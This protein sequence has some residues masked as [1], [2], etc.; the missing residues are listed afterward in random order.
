M[1]KIKKFV[2]AFSL[3]EL[4][5]SLIIMAAIAAAFTPVITKK[6]KA[7]DIIAGVGSL[8]TNCDNE[9]FVGPD[10]NNYCKLCNGD[11][12]LACTRS[13]ENNEYLDV[14]SCK[15]VSCTSAE[16]GYGPNCAKCD[17]SK[18]TKC[19]SGYY[20]NGNSCA[21]CSENCTE[22]NSNGCKK[23]EEGY[24]KISNGTC[25]QCGKGQKWTNDGCES[26]EPGTF[27]PEDAFIG[28]ECTP[29]TPNCAQCDS[30]TGICSNC[31]DGYNLNSNS[32]TCV[33]CPAGS[34]WN[35]GESQC[36]ANGGGDDPICPS[37]EVATIKCGDWFNIKGC[38]VCNGNAGCKQCVE[39]YH[40]VT[41][42]VNNHPT[43]SSIQSC[44]INEGCGE[45]NLP[46]C[47]TC[48]NDGTK[49]TKCE[50][51]YRPYNGVCV[52][53]SLTYYGTTAW[54]QYNAGAGQLEPDSSNP[55]TGDTAQ[56]GPTIPF[57]GTN[58]G[59]ESTLEGKVYKCTVGQACS[60][61]GGTNA[62]CWVTPTTMDF[63]T[64][65]C[66]NGDSGYLG[67]RRT[68]CNWYAANI[69]CAYNGMS[70]PSGSQF[71]SLTTNQSTPSSPSYLYNNTGTHF[72]S[73][74][75]SGAHYSKC[76]QTSNCYGSAND[77]SCKPSNIWS[78]SLTTSNAT[79]FPLVSSTSTGMS[80]TGAV[81]THAYSVRC[82]IGGGNCNLPHCTTCNNDGTKCTK[83]ESGYFPYN[84]VCVKTNTTTYVKGH[85]WTK[86]NAGAGQLEPDS[87]NPVTADTVQYGP[88]IPFKGLN[89]GT[90]SSYEEKI[91]KCTVGQAC[92]YGGTTPTCWVATSSADTSGIC[93]TTD[94]YS[95]CK[96]TLC[97]WYAANIIC[98]YNGMTL[99]ASTHT[100]N[101]WSSN[102]VDL[103]TGSIETDVSGNCYGDTERTFYPG[104]TG[105]KSLHLCSSAYSTTSFS[106]CGTSS[107]SCMGAYSNK[108]Y[109]SYVADSGIT[110]SSTSYFN[111]FLSY[112]SAG[113]FPCG[114]SVPILH[115][116]GGV[117]TDL[118]SP[119][120]ID[121][122][123]AASVRCIS[124]T[125][126]DSGNCSSIS[127][128][129]SCAPGGSTCEDC[130]SGYYLKDSECK[131][132]QPHCT[133][134]RYSK[135]I[136]T[137]KLYC[138]NC[139][140]GYYKSN[141]NCA[142]CPTG[143]T[144]C[145]L[146]SYSTGHGGTS[147]ASCSSCT[148]GYYQKAY[149]NGYTCQK[150]AS[151]YTW[152]GTACVQNSQGNDCSRLG[153][154]GWCN[155]LDCGECQSCITA[156][157]DDDN[158]CECMNSCY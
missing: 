93:D 124:N 99:P 102:Y 17:D 46:H 143:C 7:S 103:F 57:Q 24:K 146:T 61:V 127:H 81:K 147:F 115:S 80:S 44:E 10:G 154:E 67:C 123:V 70:I 4:T 135:V 91:E 49:C 95:G 3:I 6:I 18:C 112:V 40:L 19:I 109:P 83:C 150:C 155:S 29:C 120:A 76:M 74:T 94:G 148:S 66:D 85:Y 114:G 118:T 87:A 141:N 2:K 1:E 30:Q 28:T 121:K 48:N 33:Q 52:A 128:C 55:A 133:V 158:W 71:I 119:T 41:R 11:N 132:C 79:F 122:N 75:G 32:N 108:C 157:H 139:E 12:C 111:F 68:V 105:P 149:L 65:V 72:C 110:V 153:A 69:I 82:V 84:G 20:L 78:T 34:T 144:N 56:Y 137:Y 53:P 47:T 90:G 9:N 130:S 142:V 36:V 38:A 64:G 45:C 97:N 62:V 60:Y 129:A 126:G 63:S 116:I 136:G 22:C 156:Y 138:D 88:T 89:Y 42:A 39:G 59:T 145:V 151:G 107:D 140:S 54:T 77:N 58:Y 101:I 31:E 37:G 25:V 125:Q 131:A 43:I 8:S 104:Y 50:S 92:S 106:R 21:P 134:C 117:S 100:S 86:Y 15:C 96:R 152:N 27:Q 16:N 26:C 51:G 98:A 35:A 5:I 13:C 73:Q 113:G 14:Y 23:C